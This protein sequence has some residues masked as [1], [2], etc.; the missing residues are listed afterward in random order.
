MKIIRVISFTTF[1]NIS[2]PLSVNSLVFG[3]M[4]WYRN[5]KYFKVGVILSI[6][7]IVI[8]TFTLL[9]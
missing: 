2:I 1:E 9:G 6:I 7:G 8:S 3:V 4:S 5:R